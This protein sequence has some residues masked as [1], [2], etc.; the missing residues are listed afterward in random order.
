MPYLVCLH[1]D[2]YLNLSWTHLCLGFQLKGSVKGGFIYSPDDCFKT[3]KDLVVYI[4]LSWL[5][6]YLPHLSSN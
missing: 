4:I 2:I 6:P 3:L 5:L 1:F